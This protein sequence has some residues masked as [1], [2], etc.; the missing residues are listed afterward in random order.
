MGLERA[1]E[2]HM[3]SAANKSTSKAGII[4]LHPILNVL[5]EMNSER[6]L[7]RL[8]TLILDTV[9]QFSNS[10]R[11]SIAFFKGDRFNAQLSRDKEQNELRHADIPT[12]GT[13]LMRVNETGETVVIDDVRADRRIRDGGLLPG[14]DA[15][16]IL[17]LPLRVKNRLVGAVYLDNTQMTHAFGPRHRDL[18]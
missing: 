12:L 18:A 4:G 2:R 16:A 11:G 6:N 13:A 9:I 1:R 5:K 8:I 17:C 15:R 14:Y 3:A 10:T 7:R